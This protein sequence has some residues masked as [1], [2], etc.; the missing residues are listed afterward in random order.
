MLFRSNNEQVVYHIAVDGW[1][2]KYVMM[3]KGAQNDILRVAFDGE[4]RYLVNDTTR[5]GNSNGNCVPMP[6]PTR[7]VRSDRSRWT[8]LICDE[9]DSYVP[10][11]TDQQAQAYLDSHRVRFN[12]GHIQRGNGHG[13]PSTPKPPIDPNGCRSMNFPDP[14][15]GRQHTNPFTGQ[16]IQE[17]LG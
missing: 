4:A 12:E 13:G 7:R 10:S 3:P 16:P 15:P 1:K 11:I 2:D 17:N 8:T 6:P 14:A 5:D 9:I